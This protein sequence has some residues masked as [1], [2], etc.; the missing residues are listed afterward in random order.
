MSTRA[1]NYDTWDWEFG[2]GLQNYKTDQEEI[3][4]NILTTIKSWK[5]D[6]FFDLEHGISWK[7]ILGSFNTQNLIK[8]DISVAVLGVEGV[9]KINSLELAL[10]NNRTITITLNIDTIYNNIDIIEDLTL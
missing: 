3:T 7:E 5:N 10:D 9:E 1:I 8:K 4:Q 2:Q 6:C